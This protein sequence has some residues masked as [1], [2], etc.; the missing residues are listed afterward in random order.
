MASETAR[1]R[2]LS[3]LNQHSA[4]L[5]VG[6]YQLVLAW[7][8]SDDINTV[9]F[10]TERRLTS[11]DIN[12]V[13]FVTE[14]R[15]TSDDINTVPFVTERRLTSDDINTVPFMTERRDL[16][17]QGNAFGAVI[18]AV[19]NLETCNN[20]NI[21]SIKN[22]QHGRKENCLVSTKSLLIP[23]PV[24]YGMKIHVDSKIL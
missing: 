5:T 21:K 13:P 4:N 6:H 24:N 20:C 9:P 12:T 17:I 2:I 14:R 11:D 8:T 16:F 1:S 15:L 10:M 19:R 22:T 18:E 7:L 3:V 23:V